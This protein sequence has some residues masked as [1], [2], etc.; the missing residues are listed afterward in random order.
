ASC[1]EGWPNVLLEAMACGTPVV[2]TAVGAVPDFVDHPH[3]GRVVHTRAVPGIAAAI[4][5]LLE[6][7]PT[8]EQ[9]RQYAAQFNWEDTTQRLLALFS[10]VIGA[11]DITN[12]RKRRA[13]GGFDRGVGEKFVHEGSRSIET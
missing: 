5:S 1:Q 13:R 3:A 9:V 8:R 2:A 6:N 7:P 4:K 11:S 12:R 10:E